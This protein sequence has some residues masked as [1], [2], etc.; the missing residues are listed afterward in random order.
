M[1]LTQERL[2]PELERWRGLGWVT[3]EGAESI[4][5]LYP[6]G[7]NYWMIAFTMIGGVLVLGGIILLIAHNWQVIPPLVK[8]GTLLVLLTGSTVFAVETQAR[9]MDRAWWE[10]GFLGAAVFPLLGLMLVSQIFHVQGD[11]VSLFL[12]WGVL[13]APLVFL[14]RSLSVWVTWLIAWLVWI[15]HAHFSGWWGWTRPDFDT[16]CWL[17]VLW[18]LACAGLSQGWDRLQLPR[19]REAGE[20]L[21]LVVGLIAGYLLGFEVEF[22]LSVWVTV[23]LVCMGLIYL[24]YRTARPQRVN[25]G[26]AMI[27]VVILSVFI[28]L[29]GTMLDTG[30]T[31]LSGGIGILA[32]VYFLN[33]LRKQVLLR[34]Q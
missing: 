27:G 22:W 23:F 19:H 31:F 28:R 7:R 30:L 2:R 9:Q 13:I 24:G 8:M 17:Y 10:P 20:Q 12:V 34:I 26:F 29:A 3:P 16:Y 6:V 15:G 25:L 32:G 18:G 4:L 5:G 33:R 14:S 21:G 1:K 11:P